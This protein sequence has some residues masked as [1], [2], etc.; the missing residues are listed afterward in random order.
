MAVV[1]AATMIPMVT[2]STA[3]A[4]PPSPAAPMQCEQ[5]PITQTST[6]TIEGAT[7]IGWQGTQPKW[8]PERCR[9]IIPAP[10]EPPSP[11]PW[12]YHGPTY[13]DSRAKVVT[14][15]DSYSSGTGTHPNGWHYD[16]RYGGEAWGLKLTVRTDNECWR[17]TDTTPGPRLAAATGAASIF[18]AC[19][20]ALVPHVANQFK[21]LNA[22]WPTDASNGWA[23]T[24]IVMTVG[25]NDIATSIGRDWP[26]IVTDC[27]LR[28]PLSGCQSV[29]ANQISNWGAVGTSLSAL[30][31]DI[32]TRAPHA[33]IRVLAYPY[34]MRADYPWP[35]RCPGVP[36]I[37]GN[38][39]DWIDDQVDVL[40]AV[41]ASAIAGVK[42][43]HPAVDIQF[44]P[45]GS[46]FL[47]G[48]CAPAFMR[49]SQAIN[50]YML[51]DAS[52]HPTPIGYN[53]F[54][55]MLFNSL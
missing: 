8:I 36:G 51:T 19:K 54:K 41:I 3:S 5:A 39:A 14:L 49:P 17:E 4:A 25:G 28:P 7:V 23:D 37:N 52:F 9:D 32:A 42:A 40:N 48:A 10:Y 38:E 16:E 35:A 33:T 26:G 20:G 46:R 29:S 50:T 24:T 15:G 34:L 45:V 6:G 11:P 30:Y 22:Q 31:S 55:S 43:V 47:I 13:S 1:A 21:L 27:I 44:V 53:D 2:N 18:M 12:T